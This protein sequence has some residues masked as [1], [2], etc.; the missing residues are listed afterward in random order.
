[1]W[2]VNDFLKWR[3]FNKI[4]KLE[5]TEDALAK[6]DLVYLK[7]LEGAIANKDKKLA[8]KGTKELKRN[9]VPG[10]NDV[11]HGIM[12]SVDSLR[13][14]GF[15][16]NSL[17][18]IDEINKK[19]NEHNKV[20]SDDCFPRFLKGRVLGLIK[21]DKWD[22]LK[23]LIPVLEGAMQSWIK[24]DQEIGNIVSG[25]EENVKIEEKDSKP[26]IEI[27]GEIEKEPEIIEQPKFREKKIYPAILPSVNAIKTFSRIA[28]ISWKSTKVTLKTV[29]WVFFIWIWINWVQPNL[30]WLLQKTTYHQ[31]IQQI[32]IQLHNKDFI[33]QFL[34]DIPKEK[35]EVLLRN[36]LNENKHIVEE[37]LIIA[38]KGYSNEI[39]DI[40]IGQIYSGYYTIADSLGQVARTNPKIDLSKLKRP[41][42]EQIEAELLNAL[43]KSREQVVEDIS[44]TLRNYYTVTILNGKLPGILE[45]AEDIFALELESVWKGLKWGAA[46]PD[47]KIKIEDTIRREI[48]TLLEPSVNKLKETIVNKV[49]GGDV[50]EAVTNTAV[51]IFTEPSKT[52]EALTKLFNA[53]KNTGLTYLAICLLLVSFGFGFV[54]WKFIRIFIINY[55]RDIY[56]LIKLTL[57]K[58]K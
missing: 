47:I 51:T 11:H 44:I 49:L 29:A 58:T 50:W 16:E 54:T 46:E 7:E 28:N 30:K 21:N 1:M 12:K 33:K 19:I 38:L 8:E 37:Q 52:E 39:Y 43:G 45:L 15:L 26:V 18:R 41:I 36:V 24:L 57:E 2:N 5:K 13:K 20:I 9:I 34:N 32:E 22:E 53:L 3:G 23:K 56:G 4:K 27:V 25:E 35:K 40:V 42:K 6:A 10:L 17:A 14:K 55:F 48:N 31:T